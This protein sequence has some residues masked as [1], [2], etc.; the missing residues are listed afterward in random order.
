MKKL[1][2]QIPK[3]INILHKLYSSAQKDKIKY[4]M[5]NLVLRILKNDY[6]NDRVKVLYMTS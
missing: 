3:Y 4:G 2:T 5:I 6:M 1:S